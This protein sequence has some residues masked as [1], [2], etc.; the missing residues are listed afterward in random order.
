MCLKIVYPLQRA[1]KVELREK[2]CRGC[3]RV[4]RFS[5]QVGQAHIAVCTVSK[6]SAFRKERFPMNVLF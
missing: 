3:E 4:G 2:L 6:R 5:H 1:L